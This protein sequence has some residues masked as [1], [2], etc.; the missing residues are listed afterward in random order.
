VD[1]PLEVALL[2][3]RLGLD[4]DGWPL[5]PLL[6]R[7]ERRRITPRVFCL[8]RGAASGQDPRFLE[9]P[10]LA[11]RWL[12]AI[13]VRRLRDESGV[14]SPR[15]IHALH[16][17]T[18]EVVLALADHWRVPYVQTVDD[19]GVVERG[20]RLSRHWCRGLVATSREL[21]DELV[22]GL[23]FPA[24]RVCVISPGISLPPSPQRTAAWKVPVVGTA[25]PPVE[26][27]GFA[28]FLEAARR[29]LDSG[30]DA[31]FLIATQGQD[32]IDLRRHAQSQSI[33]DRVS[34]ADFPVSGDQF[35][36]V[37]DVYCQPS[38]VPSTGRT[39]TLALARGIPCI[40][41]NVRGLHTLVDHGRT[42]VIVPV[43]CAEELAGA[44]TGILDD[45]SSAQLSGS[46]GQAEIRARF[47]LDVEADLLARL[48]RVRAEAAADM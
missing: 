1:E 34:I 31:E 22:A 43:D 47:D 30:R 12:R 45:P 11:N 9:F 27:S 16:D 41:S 28:C 4:D 21:A 18:A 46:R 26:S 10:G 13:T 8:S 36:A 5:S 19:F 14:V 17:E 32:A 38:L 48:Y 35:W 24:D 6:D 44:I 40:A 37:L 15:L 23:Q 2:A 25:G 42:G 7:L 3:G 33:S 39:L 29:V 20:I